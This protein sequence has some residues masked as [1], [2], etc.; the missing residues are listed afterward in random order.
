[1]VKYSLYTM[2]TL[3]KIKKDDAN[4]KTPNYDW[5]YKNLEQK[6]QCVPPKYEPELYEPKN[7]KKT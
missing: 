5:L 1:M 2:D 3:P 7:Q 6:G 4:G